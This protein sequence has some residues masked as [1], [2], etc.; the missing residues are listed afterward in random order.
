MFLIICVTF[1][2][3]GTHF[4]LLQRTYKFVCKLYSYNILIANLPGLTRIN[5][6]GSGLQANLSCISVLY[7]MFVFRKFIA[8]TKNNNMTCRR[9]V[10][11]CRGRREV[12]EYP[13]RQISVFVYVIDKV[14]KLRHLGAG[15]SLQIIVQMNKNLF[16]SYVI[17]GFS[18]VLL[19]AILSGQKPFPQ[20]FSGI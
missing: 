10:A 14:E 12:Q 6:E 2:K 3:H 17:I 4:F 16:F 18:I 15:R 9:H 11:I 7:D 5:S 1:L 8:I 20:V 19:S 13:L